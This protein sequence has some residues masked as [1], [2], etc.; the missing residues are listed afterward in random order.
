MTI[1]SVLFWPAL[2]DEVHDERAEDAEDEESD[3]HV[4]D[5]TDVVHLKQ[6][7]A[8]RK[9]DHIYSYLC[10]HSLNNALYI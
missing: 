10:F 4:V 2:V 6:I 1:W 5:G 8:E 7:T 3:E 9:R